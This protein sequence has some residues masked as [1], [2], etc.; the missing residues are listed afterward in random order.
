MTN[1]YRDYVAYCARVGVQPMTELRWSM[2]NGTPPGAPTF[3]EAVKARHDAERATA[4]VQDM[5]PESEG[6][7]NMAE[8]APR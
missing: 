1:P 5:P 6:R 2:M 8:P 7:A 4:V 3:A